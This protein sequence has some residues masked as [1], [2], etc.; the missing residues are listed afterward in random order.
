MEGATLNNSDL[1][2]TII[3][4]I[5]VPLQPLTLKWFRALNGKGIIQNDE[6]M[7]PVYLNKS[8]KNLVFSLKVRLYLYPIGK[9]GNLIKPNF[10][11]ERASFNPVHLITIISSFTQY[12]Y[13]LIVK[14]LSVNMQSSQS[15]SFQTQHEMTKIFECVVTGMRYGFVLIQSPS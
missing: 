12:I 3:Q 4:D 13:L 10:V 5:S 1:S 8:R 2:V 9:N 14:F 15:L 7:L 11:P 6:I